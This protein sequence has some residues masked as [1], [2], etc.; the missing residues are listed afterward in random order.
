MDLKIYREAGRVGFFD[1]D[2]HLRVAPTYLWRVFQTAAGEHARRLGVATEMLRENGQT[3]MLSKM[4]VVVDRA[5][6]IGDEWTVETWP[7]TKIRGARA[8]RDFAL[9]DTNGDVVARAAS[10]WVIVDLGTRRLLRVPDAILNLQTDPGYVIPELSDRLEAEEGASGGKE[11]RAEWSDC[12]QNEHVNNVPFVRWAVD[13]LPAEVLEKR[14]FCDVEVH[15]QRE[16]AMGEVVRVSG[17]RIVSIAKGDG[18]V[19][20]LA[21]FGWREN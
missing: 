18:T 11:F 9:K 5:L 15:Y 10:L 19:A 21:K 6:T 1:V 16:V 12:D 8:L 2:P 17:E 3:W 14:E 20:A 13:S 4:R 7:S